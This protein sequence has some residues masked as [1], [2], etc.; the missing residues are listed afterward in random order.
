VVREHSR[1]EEAARSRVGQVIDAVNELNSSDFTLSVDIK[2][3]LDA[4]P[5][6]SAMKSGISSWLTALD[7]QEES[8]NYREGGWRALPI[9]VYRFGLWE[10]ECRAFPYRSKTPASHRRLIGIGPGDTRMSAVAENTRT[11]ISSKVGRYGKLD[12]P[13]AVA[14]NVLEHGTENIDLVNALFGSEIYVANIGHDGSHMDGHLT[15]KPDGLWTSPGGAKNTRVSQVLVG[16][17]VLPWHISTAPLRLFENPFAA[18]PLESAL[19][20]LPR[21]VVENEQIVMKD[22]MNLG[23]LFELP[24]S[25]PGSPSELA[26]TSLQIDPEERR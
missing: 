18:Q 13:Y 16:S 22:G 10:L 14:V 7:Y 19:S 11:K 9:H 1:S 5:P 6:L 25:W 26:T 8:Q 4:T 24:E 12:A 20:R 15:R 2:G 21:G 17:P 23:E 3:S